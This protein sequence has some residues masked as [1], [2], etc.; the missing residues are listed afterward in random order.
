VYLTDFAGR[1]IGFHSRY[2]E[3]KVWR[4]TLEK[5]KLWLLFLFFP[6]F[7]I[8]WLSNF[9]TNAVKKKNSRFKIK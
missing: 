3:S 8:V 9:N 5:S 4:Y 7:F 6:Y 2:I 1:Y